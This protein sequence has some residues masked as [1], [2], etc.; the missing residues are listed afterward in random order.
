ML[1]G[2]AAPARPA[3][4]QQSAFRGQPAAKA[5]G[6][7]NLRVSAMKSPRDAELFATLKANPNAVQLVTFDPEFPLYRLNIEQMDILEYWVRQG[8][9]VW[10]RNCQWL[11]SAA[12]ASK[13]IAR[14]FGITISDKTQTTLE[15]SLLTPADAQHPVSQGVTKLRMERSCEGWTLSLGQRSIPLLTNGDGACVAG[16][17][18][19]GKGIV[20][21]WPTF[22]GQQPEA[23]RFHENLLTLAAGA[24]RETEK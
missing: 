20:V 10:I 21:V 4:G 5:G 1:L 17:N 22:Y 12:P 9:A 13:E 23:E 11:D 8:G 7:L 6:N 3:W 15:T 18:R 19:V 16:Y 14:R 2:S 24:I